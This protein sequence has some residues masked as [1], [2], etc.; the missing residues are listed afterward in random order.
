MVETSLIEND[1]NRLNAVMAIMETFR[2]HPFYTMVANTSKMTIGFTNDMKVVSLGHSPPN[3]VPVQKKLL[4]SSFTAAPIY[5]NNPDNERQ[6]DRYQQRMKPNKKE[7][8]QL[9]ESVKHPLEV[10]RILTRF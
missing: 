9:K 8:R 3:I 2:H 1:G 7:R 6:F 10:F 5:T 4:V